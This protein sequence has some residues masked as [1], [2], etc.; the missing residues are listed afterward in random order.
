VSASASSPASS[1][2]ASN[3]FA[4]AGAA[5]PDEFYDLYTM[6]LEAE[7]HWARARRRF[8]RHRLAVAS[9]LIVAVVFSAGFLAS[10]LAS[11]GYE[12]V[13]IKALSSGPSWAHPFGTDQVGRDYFS[14]TLYGVRTEAEIA[15]VIGF[16]GTLIGTLIGAVSGYLGGFVDLV[17]MRFAD[18]LLTVPPLVTILVAA[19]F[20]QVDTLFEVCVLLGCLL[21]MPVARVVRSAALVVR[22]QEYVQAARAMGASD[23]RIVRKHVLPNAISSVAVAASVMTASAVILETTLSYLGLGIGGARFYGGR[24]DTKLAS[25]GDVLAAA[26]NE[27]LFNWWGI[28]FPGLVVILIVAPI[29]FIGDGVRDALDPTQRRYVTERELTR[30]RRGPSRLT[31]LLRAMPRPEVSIRIR[32]PRRLLLLLDA[33]PRRRARERSRLRLLLEAFGV[34]ALTVAGAAAV[35]VWKVNP[36]RS[37]WALTGVDIQNVSRAAGAQ[38]QIAAVADPTQRGALFAV[39]NDTSLRTIRVYRS[40]DDGRTWSSSAG[41]SLGVDAC[42]RGEPTAA[43]DA[44][45]RE[46]VAFSVSGTCTAYDPSPYVVVA[47]RTRPSGGWTVHR[48][49]AHR[50]ADFWDDYPS[51]AAGPGGRV[52]VVWSRLL[53]WRFEG[54][55]VSSSA[56]GGSTWSNPRL[57]DGSLSTPRLP[58]ATV[59][60]DGALYVTGEDARLGIWVA[61]SRDGGKRFHVTRVA[62]LPGNRSVDCATAS[63]HPTPFQGIRCLGPNPTVAATAGRVFVTYGVGWPGETQN[64][65]IGVLDSSLQRIWS[66]PAGPADP[67]AD[68]FWPA[69]T[70]DRATGR[71]WVCFYD[72]SG[73]KSRKQAWF[74]CTHSRDGRTWAQPLRVARDSASPE[75]L[76]EDA[77]VYLFGDVI[78]FGGYTAVAAAGGV[79]HPMWI[80]T[81]DLRGNKQEVFGA[82]LTAN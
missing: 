70:L 32:M 46:Y 55:V 47:V 1:L 13:N 2:Q 7:G 76:W 56:D 74:S 15:L 11:Y 25:I 53:R 49:G 4:S 42:A 68:R 43:V 19:A 82:A 12:E 44:R 40:S 66:G 52:Y 3:A 59:G 9:L 34:L 72:T 8:M 61:R 48:L 37:V 60:P 38:T 64:V 29:Y 33:L 67:G 65:R 16:F 5:A 35:Y 21:W 63:G 17:A 69:S 28:V 77:R 23:L 41:P 54:I 22:E 45:G 71:L 39:S 50:P 10:H 31:R 26:S 24:T 36:V 27:G 18:L 58:R 75:V 20:L 51:V 14:R 78:G 79:A 62:R 57:I 30:R 81:R 73:D 6:D 80:D